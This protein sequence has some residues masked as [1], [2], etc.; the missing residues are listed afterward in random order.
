M[1]LWRKKF[2]TAEDRSG[3]LVRF[4]DRHVARLIGYDK[5]RANYA[6]LNDIPQRLREHAKHMK[7]EIA[8]AR[9]QLKTMERD[10]LVRAGIR[11]LADRA[12]GAK[13]ELDQAERELAAGEGRALGIRPRARCFRALGE[14]P[15]RDADRT[16]GDRGL[17]RR[18]SRRSTKRRR[19]HLRLT[20]TR[21]SGTLRRPTTLSAARRTRW[22]LSGRDCASLRSGARRSN[23]SGTFSASRAMT[24]HTVVSTTGVRLETCSAAS[25]EA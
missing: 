15:Y 8:N 1:Y 3:P 11:P 10:A 4:F 12:R 18:R 23:G 19:R 20:T 9:E 7:A 13:T 5:A 21:S 24:D 16:P 17:C 2:G 22:T 25:S 14:G 6:L